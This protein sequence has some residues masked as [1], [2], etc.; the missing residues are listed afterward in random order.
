MGSLLM[1][2]TG[3]GCAE[4]VYTTLAVIV[5]AARTADVTG[6]CDEIEGKFSYSFTLP[7]NGTR[8]RF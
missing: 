4:V 8:R 6:S 5:E 3:V 1:A 2:L 7:W